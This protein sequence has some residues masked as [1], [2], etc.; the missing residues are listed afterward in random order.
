MRNLSCAKF[1][2]LQTMNEVGAVKRSENV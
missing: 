2:E 1:S